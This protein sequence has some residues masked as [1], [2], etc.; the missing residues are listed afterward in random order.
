MLRYAVIVDPYSTGQEYPTAFRDAGVAAVAVMTKPEPPD[1]LRAS[2][3]PENFE[4][5]VVFDGDL[6]GLAR[7]LAAFQPLCVIPGTETGVELADS[8]VELVAPGTGHDIALTT[9]R[10]D[11]WEMAE[12]VRRAGVPHLRQICSA[13]KSEIDRWLRD[14]GLRDG[15]FVLKP[16][17]S[18]ATD[19]VHIVG[20][21]DDWRAAFDQIYGYTNVLDERN[22]A[23]LVEEYAEGNEYLIDGYSVDGEH[24]LVDVCRYTKVRRG[25]RIG[26]YD[27]VDFLPPDHP[28]VRAAW[29]YTIRV[30]DALGFRNGCS[31]AEVVLT[32]DGPR[33]LE[34]A[35]RPAGGGHQMITKLATGDNHI[36]RTVAHRVRGEFHKSY[37]LI[38]HV[39]SVVIS[40]PCTGIWRNAEIFADVGSLPTYHAE[41]FVGGTG[42]LVK[43]TT[44]LVSYLG[45]VVLVSSDQEAVAADYRRIK[46]LERQIQVD[47]VESTADV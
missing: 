39:C 40:A 17:R 22:D 44:D 1:V 41:H 33:L 28:E 34:V 43:E 6:P 26:I 10:R 14:T 16:P 9:A 25:D 7:R 30:L 31:H 21:G 23:V 11:K 45:W 32:A 47:P 12:A 37:Q 19:S 4:H 46:E 24:G 2:W 20:P 18:A 35:A 38:Q 42:D 5:V 15:L 29:P 36:L 8:L 3:H 27:L 13:D